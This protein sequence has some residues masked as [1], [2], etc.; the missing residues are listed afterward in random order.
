MSGFSPYERR[1]VA[2]APRVALPAPAPLPFERARALRSF[3]RVTKG[4]L[5]LADWSRAGLAPRLSREEGAFWL[6]ALGSLRVAQRETPA[7]RGGTSRAMREHDDLVR[8]RARQH[9]LALDVARPRS[10]AEIAEQLVE[11]YDALDWRGMGHREAAAALCALIGVP[12][13]LTVILDEANDAVAASAARRAATSVPDGW[14]VL[15]WKNAP[16]LQPAADTPLAVLATRDLGMVG[17]AVDSRARLHASLAAG[18]ADAVAP[19]LDDETFEAARAIAG[20]AVRRTL[21]RAPALDPI[22]RPH[23]P[24]PPACYLAGALHLTAEAEAVV[25]WLAGANTRSE[26]AYLRT[27]V[28][29][30]DGERAVVAAAR[31]FRLRLER[32]AALR[33]WLATTGP[34]GIDFAAEQIAEHVVEETSD[35]FVA[36]LAALDAPDV[37]PAMLGLTATPVAYVSARTWLESNFE[38]VLPLL[39]RERC[40]STPTA[41]T[42]DEIVLRF[43]R[44]GHPGAL[45]PRRKEH[46]VMDSPGARFSAYDRRWIS[47]EPRVPAQRA[48]G[49]PFE[50][51]AALRR[52]SESLSGS[53][54]KRR[55]MVPRTA[56]SRAEGVFWFFAVTSPP[57]AA[58]DLRLLDLDGELTIRDVAGVI[59]HQSSHLGGDVMVPLA[60]VFDAESLLGLVLG[61]AG[62]LGPGRRGDRPVQDALAAGFC[63]DVAPY[64]APETFAACR[65]R[66]ERAFERLGDGDAPPYLYHLAAALHLPQRVVAFVDGPAAVAHR[67]ELHHF[68]YGLG[69]PE[70]TLAAMARYE[71]RLYDAQDIREWLAITGHAGIAY[72]FKAITDH[73]FDVAERIEALAGIDAAETVTGMLRLTERKVFGRAA[74]DWLDR[75]PSLTIPGALASANGS[76]RDRSIAA[77]KRA[78]ALGHG[79]AIAAQAGA[80][81]RELILGSP[82]GGEDDDLGWLDQPAGTPVRWLYADALPALVVAGRE[83]DERAA[84]AVVDAL[85]ASTLLAPDARIRALVRHATVESRERFALA[86]FEQWLRAG[87]TAKDKWA[88]MA[89]GLLGG[90]AAASALVPY[91]RRW[92][93]ESQHARA[94]IG[95]ECLRA[96]GS[97]VA[98]TMIAGLAQKLKFTALKQRAQACLGEIALERKLTRDQ[99]EDRIVPALDLERGERP[100]VIR[101]VTYT[102]SLDAASNVV[103]RGPAGTPLR[104]LP[105]PAGDESAEDAQTR[106]E[107]K[108]FKKQLREVANVQRDRLEAAM[109]TQRMWSAAEFATLLVAHPVLGPFIRRLVW[110]A[111]LRG[112]HRPPYFRVVDGGT[113]A[114]A[115]GIAVGLPESATVRLVHRLDLSEGDLDAWEAT[116][117]AAGIAQPFSQLDRTTYRLDEVELA[118]DRIRRFDGVAVP[119]VTIQGRLQKRGWQRGTPADGGGYAHHWKTFE[120]AGVTAILHHDLMFVGYR[121][122]DRRI[123]FEGCSF[124]AETGMRDPEYGDP[125]PLADAGA[126][127]ISEV[128]ADCSF[129]LS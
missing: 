41:K 58:D 25:A 64:L 72:A 47:W 101:G 54:L 49:A 33:E 46:D 53:W 52:W 127:P 66:V 89:V 45:R 99:L 38:T 50:R 106:A 103:L 5:Y 21:S 86:L 113:Y 95:L 85:R 107:W 118:A 77:L 30:L 115:A 3:D 44:R 23:E 7:A 116:F 37:A 83:L 61:E 55:S 12:A 73:D 92:P 80:E 18:F 94:V 121:D 98:L 96:I 102:A 128:C 19:Y 17:H 90:D 11:A 74:R 93:G 119:E 70:R 82:G 104:D 40:G 15:Y 51:A 124:T 28:Y 78:A 108:L 59:G 14:G 105:K 97:D 117:A 29:G 109:V 48:P 71:L 34:A 110:T 112:E 68:V 22:A 36:A 10:P 20:P 31:S 24:I 87:A 75:N 32:P 91:V 125:V 126:V 39:A 129:V 16:D 88:L 81:L 69:S 120:R 67:H 100:F 43:A 42:A 26:L 62:D 63:N 13:A 111:D 6:A 2:R 123:A 79:D 65:A 114:D 27:L 8:T 35:A 122:T 84:L 1:W 9:L 57:A 56:M 60:S 4:A 76:L